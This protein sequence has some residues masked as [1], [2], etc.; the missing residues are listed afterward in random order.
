M[1]EYDDNNAEDLSLDIRSHQKGIFPQLKVMTL[2]I[3][4]WRGKKQ[5][6]NITNIFLWEADAKTKQ[7]FQNDTW[8]VTHYFVFDLN[9]FR[10]WPF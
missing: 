9:S 5:I 2:T 7:Q 4:N 1:I 8:E 6:T 3:T 10:E